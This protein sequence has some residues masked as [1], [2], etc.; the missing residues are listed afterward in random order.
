MSPDVS[1]EYPALT[2]FRARIA[3]AEGRIGADDAPAA[4]A[5][6]REYLRDGARLGRSL[7]DDLGK[8]RPA[9]AV[10]AALCYLFVVTIDAATHSG[11]E[12]ALGAYATSEQPL[13]AEAGE[14]YALLTAPEF[15]QATG[16]RPVVSRKGCPR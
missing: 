12:G 1:T 10:G 11:R 16:P 8:L 2:A 9:D 3:A 4:I 13:A 7:R 15:S 5:V 14:L 6:L